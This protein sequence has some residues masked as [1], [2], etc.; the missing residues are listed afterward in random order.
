MPI[1][2][3]NRAR[4]PKEWRLI[5]LWIR[6][7][8][9]WRCEWCA[10]VHGKPHPITGSRVI[11]TVAHVLNDD[12]ADVRP[13]NLAALCQRCHNRHDIPARVAG[14]QARFRSSL[15]RGDLLLEADNEKGPPV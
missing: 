7:C 9:G 12:P 6:V 4:Y 14:R 15:A 8:A 11:L 5:S 10:A 1:R 3:E 13:A 2:A